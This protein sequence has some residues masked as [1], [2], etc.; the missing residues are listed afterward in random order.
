MNM[1]PLRLS[2]LRFLADKPRGYSPKGLVHELCPRPVYLSGHR[3][4]WTEQGAARMAGKITKPLRD[5]GLIKLD[6]WARMCDQIA[7]ITDD[8]RRVLAEH[9]AAASRAELARAI[10]SG[11]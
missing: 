8:G 3:A 6:H 2:I 7:T 11:S 5:A 9:D 10:E 1:T 4:Q